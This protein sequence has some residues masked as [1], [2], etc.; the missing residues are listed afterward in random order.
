MLGLGRVCFGE[1]GA[2]VYLIP[3]PLLSHFLPLHS[4]PHSPPAAHYLSDLCSPCLSFTLFS[5]ICY[6]QLNDPM[7]TTT[8]ADRGVYAPPPPATPAEAGC[9]VRVGGS[10]GRGEGVRGSCFPLPLPRRDD[11]GCGDGG[12]PPSIVDAEPN[13]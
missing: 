10:F 9:G 13:T 1:A 4:Q 3:T 12:I 11:G 5:L 7:L 8:T 6:R 2:P